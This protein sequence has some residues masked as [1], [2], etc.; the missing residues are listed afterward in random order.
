MERSSHS[1]HDSRRS[2]PQKTVNAPRVSKLNLRRHEVNTQSDHHP[3]CQWPSKA[4]SVEI[5]TGLSPC[6]ALVTRCTPTLQSSVA[7]WSM[8]RVSSLSLSRFATSDRS[9]AV[10]TEATLV[11]ESP[12]LTIR[13]RL[14]V[15]DGG[16]TDH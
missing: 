15:S 7:R 13:C 10:C 16:K 11:S 6:T 12:I 14:I 8:L 9:Q 3:G 2:M 4:K 1:R 5:A